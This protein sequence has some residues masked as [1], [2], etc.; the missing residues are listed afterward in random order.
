MFAQSTGTNNNQ[1]IRFVTEG[2]LNGSVI[3][4]EPQDHLPY[5][6][7]IVVKRLT[8]ADAYRQV[9]RYRSATLYN[10][11]NPLAVIDSEMPN[12]EERLGLWHPGQRLPTPVQVFETEGLVG[13]GAASAVLAY[14][15]HRIEGRLDGS[16]TLIIVDEG[17]LALDDPA[18]GAQL[19]EWLKT[20]RKKN[21]SVVF[22]TQSLADIEGSPIAP[23]IVESC[24]TRLFL[25]NERALE[26]QITD[27]YRRFGLNDRQI[28]ILARATP[29]R[30][31]YCQ[32]RRGNRLFE[33]GLGPV[34][35]AFAAASSKSDQATITA[36]VA[37]H[38]RVGFAAA[39]L[40]RRGLPW[41]ADLLEPMSTS[42]PPATSPL[43]IAP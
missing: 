27:I 31:Y 24:P 1:E 38:G 35:L 25:P 2:P 11:G 23:A 5:G 40:R 36:L 19:R 3:T 15:F 9:L 42:A 37:E 12:I 43:E 28:E 33:L 14:L 32:S 39:W 10:D 4:A 13:S 30:D 16:P 20:L 26:P 34:A 41:A 8:P 21:A 18:F 7:W 22:A 6:Y 17:W 29:K